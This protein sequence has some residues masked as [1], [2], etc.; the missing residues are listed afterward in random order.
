MPSYQ[1]HNT[2]SLALIRTYRQQ[3]KQRGFYRL[4]GSLHQSKQGAPVARDRHISRRVGFLCI[5]S[6]QQDDLR[7]SGP[8]SRQD[9][10]GGA[11]T[12]DRRIPA[13]L[14]ADSLAT[15]PPTPQSAG[16]GINYRMVE[17]SNT[18]HFHP[19]KKQLCNKLEK[20]LKIAKPT[21]RT[22]Q[23]KGRNTITNLHPSETWWTIKYVVPL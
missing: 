7:L 8:P 4:L 22:N 6:P 12:R 20:R 15:V 1:C 14:K 21:T 11:R 16:G 17:T 5:A 3:L 9:A 2:R 10:S 13:D 23:Y 18:V 19:V